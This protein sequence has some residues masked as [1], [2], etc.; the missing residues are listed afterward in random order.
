M[1]HPLEE[2]RWGVVPIT[3][4]KGVLVTRIIGGYSLFGKKCKTPA[5]VDAIIEQPLETIKN[6]IK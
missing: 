2:V 4:Y 3:V 5:E 1:K 6:S